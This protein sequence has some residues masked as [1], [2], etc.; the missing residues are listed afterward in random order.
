M[1]IKS[2]INVAPNKKFYQ[3]HRN[4]RNEKQVNPQT[5]KIFDFIVRI[6][7]IV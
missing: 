2:I 7:I 5:I 4:K 1:I 3:L 6:G